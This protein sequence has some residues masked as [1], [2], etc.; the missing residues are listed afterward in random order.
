MSQQQATLDEKVDGLVTTVSDLVVLVKGNTEAIENLARM[1][2]DQFDAI[3]KQVGNLESD[4]STLKS[5]VGTLK[6]DV[7]TLKSDVG[8]LKSQMV[9]K[10]YLD[11][12]LADLWGDVIVL[13]RKDDRRFL[14]LVS[15]LEKR[16]G[17]SDNDVKRLDILRPLVA[18][19]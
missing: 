14:E 10:E 17:L 19:D 5:D 3:G 8:H 2:K 7:G 18:I 4:V 13:F 9:T 16:N 12:K 1:T 11:D 15:T 6:S